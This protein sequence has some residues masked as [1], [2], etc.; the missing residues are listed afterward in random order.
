M[1]FCR[2]QE[3]IAPP[4]FPAVRRDLALVVDRDISAARVIAAIRESA[5]PLLEGVEVF[6]VYEGGS[7][8]P[9]K[10]SMA[11]ACRYRG[12]DRTLT[13]EE[14]NRAHGELIERGA[15]GAGGG[16]AAVEIPLRGSGLGDDTPQNMTK[17]DLVDLI[18]ERV[19]SSKKEACE[20]VEEVFKIIEDSL[21]RG[22]RRSR[23]PAS[24]ASP[25]TISAPAGDAILR[26]ELLSSSTRA[27]CYPSSRAR[28]SRD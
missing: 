3:V 4:R 18:Y 19:G 22:E 25:S 2:A 5:S 16:V 12:K 1:V 8:A 6:D 14:V 11:L 13:D 10:K 27:A 20:I 23:S 24:A 28:C 7:I 26:P 21:Q 17:A 9:G 15:E